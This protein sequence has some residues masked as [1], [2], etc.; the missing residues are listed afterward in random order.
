MLKYYYV[1][2]KVENGNERL[3]NCDIDD[4]ITIAD[5]L[6]YF[7]ERN[8]IQVGDYSDIYI[9]KVRQIAIEINKFF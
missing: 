5:A 7:T 8:R 2:Y 1:I 3:V 6:Y 4:L 9:T